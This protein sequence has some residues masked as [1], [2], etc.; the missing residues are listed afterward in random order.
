MILNIFCIAI[1]NVVARK[2]AH[3][4]RVRFENWNTTAQAPLFSQQSGDEGMTHPGM[5]ALL[6]GVSNDLMSH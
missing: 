1:L 2:T 5:Y 3:A 6:A 4:V